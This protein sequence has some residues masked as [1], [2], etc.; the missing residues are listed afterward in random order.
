MCAFVRLSVYSC[1]GM[2]AFACVSTC[3]CV[4]L[5]TC[6]Y[7]CVRVRTCTSVDVHA[8]IRAGVRA[9]VR[10]CVKRAILLN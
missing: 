9:C 10:V 2:R 1:A 4:L 7:V 5:R 3:V 6:A 8:G